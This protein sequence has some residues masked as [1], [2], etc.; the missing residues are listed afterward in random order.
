MKLNWKPPIL[1]GDLLLPGR[2]EGE[3]RRV[4]PYKDAPSH[5]HLGVIV[6]T[7]DGWTVITTS[8][9]EIR[10]AILRYFKDNS[11]LPTDAYIKTSVNA[12]FDKVEKISNWIEDQKGLTDLFS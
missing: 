2:E 11:A 6:Y 7:K 4:I 1:L 10:Q 3:A 8:E 12:Y 9:E 5:E